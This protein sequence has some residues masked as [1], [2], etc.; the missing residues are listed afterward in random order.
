M[1]N[2]IYA[3]IS[4]KDSHSTVE[5]QIQAVLTRHNNIALAF[6]DEGVS[7][8]TNPN[9]RAGFKRMKHFL[10]AGDTVYIYALDRVGRASTAYPV[11]LELEKIGVSVVSMRESKIDTRTP[12][13]RFMIRTMISAAEFERD[14]CSERIKAG[15]A[16]SGKKG[17]QFGKGVTEAGQR[18]LEMLQQ[19][20]SVADVMSLTG[21]SRA[22]AFRLK[23]A[24]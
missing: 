10:K 7:G 24:A 15:L 18:A 2:Y 20:H 11:L 22:T 4:K 5:T 6:C 12:A 1:A 13:G 23:K 9:N 14:L 8:T 19:G 16:R 17:H 3:R 21:V